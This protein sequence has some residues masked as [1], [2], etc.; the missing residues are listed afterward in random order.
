MS[1]AA[2]VPLQEL[3]DSWRAIWPRALAS[4]SRF[5]RL[6]PPA[7]CL[8]DEEA[9]AE[10]LT[11]S[12]AMIRLVDQ[13]VIVNLAEVARVGLRDFAHEVLAHEIG[14]H[15]LAP[16]TLTDHGRIIARMRWALPTVEKYAP[17]VANLYTDLLIND[18]L[19]R[20]AGLRMAEV[21]RALAK[22]ESAGATWRVYL[23]IY[24]ILWS[25][26]R[27]S[28]GGGKTDDREEGDALLGSRLVRS[29]AR[30]FVDGSGRF[31]ALLLPYLLEDPDSQRKIAKL[32]DTRDAGAGGEPAG[33]SEGERGEKEGAIHPAAD[34]SLSEEA[35]EADQL[36]GAEAGRDGERE[37]RGGGQA[38]QP[39]E[40]GELLKATGLRLSEHESAIRYYRERALPHLV[41]YPTRPSPPG[42]EPFPEGLEPW[43]IGDPLDAVDWLQT[44]LQSPRVFP[45]LTTV[46]RSWGTTEG[47]QPELKPLDLDLY[48]DSSGSMM[49]PRRLLSFPTL[50][51]AIICLSALRAGARVQ[52]TLWS[53]KEQFTSTPGFVRDERA[54]LGVLTGY[55]GGA[56]AFPLH[57]LR[58]TYRKR[59]PLDRVAHILV[60]SDDGVSTMFDKDE[61]GRD[62]WMI[63]ATALANARGGG[64]MVLNLPAAW[65]SAKAGSATPYEQI[66]RGRD[67]QGWHV[68]R[69]SSWEDLLTFAR[70]FSR[71]RYRGADQP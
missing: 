3:R 44:I 64:T 46:Q 59:T 56:T 6:R 11:G 42:T 23:R 22:G 18:R 21:Y 43:D 16:A 1:A 12:F 53:G 28:L 8:T 32:F 7:L 4:W 25:L 47:A 61:W 26:P 31:A 9:R 2:P 35:G 68:S 54:I 34:P 14:H 50:A 24:E 71:L 10:G 45:G 60:I 17:M 69:V 38:R 66:R 19:Q 51:G 37:A 58:E 41:P 48:V 29:Y 33:L 57:V 15:V 27:Q 39:F 13:S 65:D 30:D 55:F 63:A 70:D 67:E 52:A 5:T 49:D 20:S 40:Y 36:E 62:G